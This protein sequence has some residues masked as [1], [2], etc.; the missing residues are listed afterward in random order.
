MTSYKKVQSED[1]LSLQLLLL[2]MVFR[3]LLVVLYLSFPYSSPVTETG[4]IC[5]KLAV[6]GCQI[7]LNPNLVQL[8]SGID[9]FISCSYKIGALV[10]SQLL[11]GSSNGSKASQSVNEG[12]SCHVV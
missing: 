8:L 2:R 10:R 1:V 4:N 7:G 11:N 6:I 12:I 9:E 5:D 3:M